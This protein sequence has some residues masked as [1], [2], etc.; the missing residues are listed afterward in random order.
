[1]IKRQAVLFLA[2]FITAGSSTAPAQE[3][4]IS[5]ASEEVRVDILVTDKGKPIVDLRASDFEVIDNGVLQEIQYAEPQQQTPISAILVFDMSGSVSGVTLDR[6]KDA[7]NGFLADLK[8]EDRVAL[9]TFNHAVVLGSSLT[10]DIARV[11]QALEQTQSSGDSSLIDASYAGLLLAESRSELPLLIIFSDDLDT[12]SWLTEEAVLETAKRS[13][14]VVYAV[15][16]RRLPKQ[17]FLSDLAKFT[18][19][20]LSEVGSVDSLPAMFLRILDEFR[21]RYLVTYI[22]KGVSEGGWHK[23][24]VRVKDRKAKVRARPGY[25]RNA[26]GSS[27]DD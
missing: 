5:V 20:S 23:L 25:I 13:D 4:I 3:H 27:A 14:A 26:P 1:M 6:L 21:Q 9:I 19:G 22:P 11:K 18:G 15:T 24:E 12:F 8:G 17:S 2:M 16:T 7:A 10:N